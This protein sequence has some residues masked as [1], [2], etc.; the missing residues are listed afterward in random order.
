MILR[1]GMLA[2]PDPVDGAAHLDMMAWHTRIPIIGLVYA[3]GPVS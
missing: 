2:I 1:D 3:R